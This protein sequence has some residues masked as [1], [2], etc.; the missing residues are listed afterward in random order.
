MFFPVWTFLRTGTASVVLPALLL[1]VSCERTNP[2][3]PSPLTSTNA[4]IAALRAQGATATLGDMLPNALPCLSVSGQVVFVNTGA[5]NAFEYSS[6]A[7]AERDAT[8]ISPDGS[9]VIADQC[10]ALITWVG[11][12]HFYKRDQ[13]IAVYAGSSDD[14]LRPLEAVLGQ[15]FASREH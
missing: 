10:A 15:P 14:V 5:I 13:M 1:G 11:P 9:G 6:V 4:L 2:V 8:K 12:P 3:G 7:A